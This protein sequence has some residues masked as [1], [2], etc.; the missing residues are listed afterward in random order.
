MRFRALALSIFF[1]LL[2]SLPVAAQLDRFAAGPKA[3]FHLE[4]GNF[5]LGALGR[6][7]LDEQFALVPGIEYIFGVTSTT[8]LVF[9]GNMHYEIPLRGTTTRPY[10]LGGAGIRLDFYSVDDT[11]KSSF[12]LNLGAGVVFGTDSPIQPWVGMKVYFLDINK[13]DL[14]V[15]GGVKFVL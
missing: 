1:L 12:R 6:Y 15:Q 11:W 13:S 8:R 5:L 2:L 3:G 10:L 4:Q 14:S 9:D 7:P